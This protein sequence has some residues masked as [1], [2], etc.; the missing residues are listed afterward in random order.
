MKKIIN[1]LLVLLLS[2]SLNGMDSWRRTQNLTGKPTQ[3][4]VVKTQE[5]VARL[6]AEQL[7]VVR[8]EA[9]QLEAEQLEVAR[10]GEEVEEAARAQLAEENPGLFIRFG[11]SAILFG[12]GAITAVGLGKLFSRND[13]NNEDKVELITEEEIPQKITENPTQEPGL[14]RKAGGAV[15]LVALSAI[16][17]A[18]TLPVDLVKSIVNAQNYV[19][20]KIRNNKVKTVLLL[21]VTW[22]A[23]EA[24]YIYFDDLPENIQALLTQYSPEVLRKVLNTITIAPE[25]FALAY[26]YVTNLFG[27]DECPAI[28]LMECPATD[29]LECPATDLLECPAPEIFGQTIEA[30]KATVAE[31]TSY[32]PEI[33]EQTAEIVKPWYS[34]FFRENISLINPR[35]W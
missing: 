14:F 16:K 10:L 33:V 35:T 2:G 18:V 21:A 34:F 1:L 27:R 22:A 31:S 6:E 4:P 32:I 23:I 29:L 19:Y 28:D 12:A 11:R 20:D 26:N 9:E 30:F 15:K 5:R 13:T 17:A 3:T 7:E 8:L 24:G 25:T